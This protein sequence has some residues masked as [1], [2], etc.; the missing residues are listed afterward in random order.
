MSLSNVIKFREYVALDVSKTITPESVAPLAAVPAAKETE[1]TESDPHISEARKLGERILRD[2]ENEA[3]QMLQRALEEAERLREQARNEIEQWWAEKRSQ[4]ESLTAQARN[5]GYEEGYRAGLQEAHQ[6]VRE[7]YAGMIREAEE[8]LKQ[9]HSLKEQIIMEAEPFLVEVSC[10]IAEK[11]IGRELSVSQDWTLDVIRKYLSKRREQ[12]TITLCV[13]SR[14]FAFIQN[15]RDELLSVLDSQAELQILP[16]ANV[17]EGGF[18]IRT[19]FGSVDG[20]IDTQ[21]QEIKAAF[22]L[23]ATQGGERAGDE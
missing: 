5:A 12:G 3:E 6:S 15:A 23:I 16:D 7:Q 21:L 17:Q 11:I 14:Q 22:L 9:A 18:V 20:R 4:D 13:S 1:K 8:V 2:A 10:A 19:A